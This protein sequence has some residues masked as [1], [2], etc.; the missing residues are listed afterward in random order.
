MCT[1]GGQSLMSG[2]LSLSFSALLYETR[3]LSEPG[4]WQSAKMT[5]L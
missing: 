5:G 2:C 3:S 4:A 1:Y